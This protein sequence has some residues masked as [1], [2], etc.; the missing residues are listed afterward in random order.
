[1]KQKTIIVKIGSSS[2]TTN[3][4]M[5][6]RKRVDLLCGEVAALHSLNH[7]IVIVTSGAI[8]A[9]LAPLN[10]NIMERPTD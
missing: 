8:A 1:M 3:E 2:I 6:D 7:N 9:G 10:I 4:G 5:I